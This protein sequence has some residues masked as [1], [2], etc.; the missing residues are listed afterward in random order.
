MR[1]LAL[2]A[3]AAFLAGC[4][5]EDEKIRVFAASSLR[6]VFPL[7][8]RDAEYVFAGSDELAAQIREGADADIYASASVRA[9]RELAATGLIAEP[10]VFATNRLVVVVPRDNPARIRG[11]DDLGR[12]NVKLVLADEGVP[13]GDYAREALAKARVDVAAN[14]ASLEDGVRGVLAKVRLGE[15]DAGI[16]YATDATAAGT[17]VQTIAVPAAVQP[18]IEY[19]VAVVEGA[20]G[21][22]TLFL[23]RLLGAEG[24]RALREAGFGL[25]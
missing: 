11:L 1:R 7:V 3:V 12:E 19:A 17:D 8:D 14:V 5:G 24:R 10:L 4:G 9:A 16:V 2:L 15:A 18:R 6:D 21:E 23:E 22:S 25:P 13:A 20:A